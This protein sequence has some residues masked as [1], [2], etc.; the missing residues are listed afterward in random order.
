MSEPRPAIR[1]LRERKERHQQRGRL[2]RIAVAIV[3]VLVILV[4]LALVP[5]PGPGWLIVAVGLGILA[6]ESDR[7]ERLF[8]RILDRVESTTERLSP[9]QKGA[10]TVLALVGIGL[11]VFAT[12]R[13]EIPI[14]PG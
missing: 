6:L 4:G 13:W 14:L 10:L 2:Y 7:A 5:L 12:L 8:E 11:W 9:A 3:G 1:R